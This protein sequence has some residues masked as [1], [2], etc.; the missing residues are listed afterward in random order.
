M[1]KEILTFGD[2]LK[3]KKINFTASFFFLGGGDVDI[4]KVLVSTRFLL[5][6]KT[7]STLFVTCIMIIKLSHYI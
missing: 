3:S 2:M 7:V 1:D 6:E 5:V 4:E